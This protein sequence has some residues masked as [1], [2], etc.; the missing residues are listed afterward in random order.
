VARINITVWLEDPRIERD[1]DFYIAHSDQLQLLGCGLGEAEARQNL[2]DTI[3]TSFKALDK[4]GVLIQ[5]L[6]KRGIDYEIEP[7]RKTA[8]N[9]P[10]EPLLVGVSQ[11]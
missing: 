3:L 5:T 6:D 11:R 4:R 10:L 1:G 7:K 8:D 9:R 2:K